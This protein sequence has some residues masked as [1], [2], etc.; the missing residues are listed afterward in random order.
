[1]AVKEAEVETETAK[2]PPAAQEAEA[3]AQRQ[4]VRLTLDDRGVPNQSSDFWL[5]NSTPEE[6]I[7]SFGNTKAQESGPVKITQKVVLNYY[8]AKRLLTALN[9]TVKGYERALESMDIEP[10]A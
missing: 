9:Q 5:I 1:M 3:Q 10:K 6:V 7:L 4:P 8:N 2:E